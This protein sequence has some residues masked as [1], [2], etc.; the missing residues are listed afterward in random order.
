MPASPTAP[1]TKPR[2]HL[3]LVVVGHVD[4]GK[5]TLIGRLLADT[6]SLHEGRIEQVRKATEGLP[7]EYA[8]LLDALLEE[9][10]QNITIDT[11]RIPFRSA[12][13]DYCII[14]APGHREFLKN[15]V[16]GAAS[17]NAAVLVVDVREGLRQQSRSH[18]R[19]LSLLGISEVGVVVNK[20]DTVA[21]EQAAFTAC[22]SSCQALLQEFGI[23]TRWILPLSAR[24][25]INLAHPRHTMSWWKGPCLLEALDDFACPYSPASAPL[26]FVV[27][28]VYR[29]EQQRLIAGRVE[30][31]SLKAGDT[32]VFSPGGRQ[33]SVAGLHRW[34][35]PGADQALCGEALAL[36]LVEQ[37]YV[38][39]G[40][41]ASH[42]EDS[43]NEGCEC[44]ARIFWMHE[45]PLQVGS[46]LTLRLATQEAPCHV[47]EIRELI[48]SETLA[49]AEPTRRTSSVGQHDVAEVRLRF[50][51]PLAFDVLGGPEA[52]SRFAL[53]VS[54]QPC[55]GGRILPGT[56]HRTGFKAGVAANLF[57]EQGQVTASLRASRN[58]H[59]GCVVW[60]TG[61]SG[62]GKT[63]LSVELEHRLFLS[64]HQVYR[65]DGDNIRHG[66]SAGLGFSAA[67]RSEN[68]RRVGEA[69]KLLADAG[70]IVL[71]AF[72]SPIAADR[73]QVRASLPREAFVEI[74]VKASVEACRRRDPKGLYA[75][76]DRGEIP[77]FTGVSS[78][79]EEPQHPELTVNTETSDANA[80]AD[81]VMAYLRA[82][83]LLLGK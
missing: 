34:P 27:Q 42:E 77:E 8:F 73:A 12:K 36:S 16:T 19:L 52:T 6:G 15:M 41:I 1:E 4:H 32:L 68:I 26:R 43:C 5:S 69:A 64:G 53:Y 72:I 24:D 3:N 9:Q 22:A 71:T 61:L 39:R 79:Y 2:E 58:G 50:K 54:H 81:E 48:S 59:K 25:G 80:C 57:W 55:G 45:A 82:R 83:G 13:R 7:F 17:A 60:L 21:F 62:S 74:L 40:Q 44:S 30:S 66:L 33:A 70:M 14:D 28:D 49:E 67:D 65:L 31:G 63:T 76:A 47:E 18:A 23:A 29:R 10:R 11:T 56:Y 37:I 51:M 38:E 46:R 20:M 78:P 35:E 75:R